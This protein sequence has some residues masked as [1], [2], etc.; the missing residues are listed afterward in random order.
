MPRFVK[1]YLPLVAVLAAI[2]SLTAFGTASATAASLRSQCTSYPRAAVHLYG[3]SEVTNST[4]VNYT[5]VVQNVS[6]KTLR[7]LRAKFIPAPYI[8]S[9]QPAGL[10][11][12]K[13]ALKN[14]RPRAK[15][16]IKVVLNFPSIQ[17]GKMA[18]VT[19]TL[20]WIGPNMPAGIYNVSTLI[21]ST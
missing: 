7:H 8:V 1:M 15:L 9:S 18:Y 10:E 21:R 6:C 11:G 12:G 3:P 2:V 16:T 19:V 4:D 5:I 14:L 20:R 17:A 13:I